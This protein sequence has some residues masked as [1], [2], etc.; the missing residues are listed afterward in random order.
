[1]AMLPCPQG[2][3][4]PPTRACRG[5]KGIS[6]AIARHTCSLPARHPVLHLMQDAVVLLRLDCINDP[7]PKANQLHA[8]R[9][10][11]RTACWRLQYAC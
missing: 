7:V 6:V 1:M 10:Q 5:A 11:A 2:W 9:A 4:Q 8:S 3:F